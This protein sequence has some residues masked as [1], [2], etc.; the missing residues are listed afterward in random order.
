[1][2]NNFHV[3]KWGQRI[4]TEEFMVGVREKKIFVP[5]RQQVILH[6]NVS[7]PPAVVVRDEVI[8]ILNEKIPG[9]KPASFKL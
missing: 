5:Y 3:P 9:L 4:L 1:M 6:P 7:T 8:K 2:R